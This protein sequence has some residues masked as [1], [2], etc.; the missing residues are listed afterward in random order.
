MGNSAV[1]GPAYRRRARTM[2]DSKNPPILVTLEYDPEE[3]ARRG[4][5][6]AHRLHAMYDSRELTA[7]GRAAFLARFER[8]VDP[9][10]LLPEAERQRRAEHARKAHFARLARL[11]AEARRRKKHAGGQP[12]ASDQRSAA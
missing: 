7:A 3:M 11:S 10:G 6:G 2:S 8:E 4:R 9:D 5:I 1:G 12:D